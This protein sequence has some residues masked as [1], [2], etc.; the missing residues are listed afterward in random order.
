M[1]K[2]SF[3]KTNLKDAKIIN[4]INNSDK[5]GYLSR[6]FCFDELKKI[7]KIKNIK[8]INLSYTSKKKTF[9]G[10]HYQLNPYSENK[11]ITCLNGK[12]LDI[13][14]DLRKKSPTF[15]KIHSEILSE[16]DNKTLFVPKGFAHGFLSLVDN[17]K[18]L[19]FHSENYF[20]K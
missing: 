16:K 12:V 8:Q 11:Y 5:R 3:K 2:F 10:F 6:L 9:R 14:I 15:L 1:K 19:Y 4:R 17:C 7:N 18:L 20:C 13:I